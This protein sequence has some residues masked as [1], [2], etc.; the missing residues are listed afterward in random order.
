MENLDWDQMLSERLRTYES[1][2]HLPDG[3]KAR[4]VRSIRR[5]RMSR[6]LRCLCLAG[7]TVIA[8]VALTSLGGNKT[9]CADTRRTEIA[10]SQH[11]NETVEISG[12]L[13]LGYLRECVRRNRTAR[14]KE[15]E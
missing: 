15:D 2:T 3:F 12:W 8:I 13:L 11:T 9:K 7:I 5:S 4:F 1:N 14:R 10:A 6:R